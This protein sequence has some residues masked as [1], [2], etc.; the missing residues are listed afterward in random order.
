M[1]GPRV[2]HEHRRLMGML[3]D[4][5]RRA[6][7][8]GEELGR[9]VGWS[10]S[11]VSKIESGRTKPSVND[12]RTWID[13]TGATEEQRAELPELAQ[14]LEARR[15]S[16]VHEAGLAERQREIA[17]VEAGTTHVSNFQFA[18]IPGL[19]QTADYARRV[20]TMADVSG[21]RDVPAAV[22]QRLERQTVLYEQDKTF[23]FVLAE[24]ALRWRPGPPELIH[25][26]RD[27]LLSLLTLPNVTLSVV[28]FDREA[29][30]LYLNGFTIF[31]IP[32][33]P[34]VLVETLSHE[35]W[36]NDADHLAT[37]RRTFSNLA[38][39]AVTGQQ[40]PELIRSA[41]SPTAGQ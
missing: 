41:M 24:G 1:V 22:A 19:L 3:N 15:W 16:S 17:E 10:Q 13:A 32:D 11:K 29:T 21:Q 9:T 33:E 18:I 31:E 12:V 8:S 4:L 6:G 14:A 37:Y 34:T 2:S 30:A 23:E 36:L 40:V 38:E 28:P 26:Q 39:N 35:L 7:L 20:L 27:R 5:R 25:A